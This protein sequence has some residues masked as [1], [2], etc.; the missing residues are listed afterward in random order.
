M[1]QQLATIHA[2]RGR[3]CAVCSLSSDRRTALE[4]A[5]ATG[6]SISRIAKQD[7]APGRESITH[8]VN[9][10]HLPEQLQQQAERAQGLDHTSVV[11]RISDIARRARTSALEAAEA[12]N[13]GALARAN[14]S[15]LRA[16]MAL[17]AMGE[18]SEFEIEQR[19]AHRDLSA[20]VIHL[21]RRDPAAV[22]AVA[23]ELESM[24]R[25]LLAEEIRDQYPD[26]ENDRKV[27]E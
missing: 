11:A 27:S 24:Y 18:T 9:S 15:E 26:S 6:T 20:A 13:Q 7:W 8:H 4:T 2:R 3:P 5:L 1:T 22:E 23:D 21:A 17:S 12:G 25:P 10:G 14:D 19:A 16:L